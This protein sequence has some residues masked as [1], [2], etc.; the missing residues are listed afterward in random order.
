MKN[1]SQK[2]FIFN[3]IL[4]LIISEI[5]GHSVYVFYIYNYAF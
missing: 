2:L 1:F 4:N 3:I 5:L